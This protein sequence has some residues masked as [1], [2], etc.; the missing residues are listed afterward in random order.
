MSPSYYELEYH[1][2]LNRQETESLLGVE[3]GAYLVRDT[4]SGVKILS[5]M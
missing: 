1:G 5:F 2:Y 3:D 4:L